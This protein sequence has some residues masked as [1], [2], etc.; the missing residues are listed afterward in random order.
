[1]LSAPAG[2]ATAPIR[3][4]SYTMLCHKVECT[5]SPQD[6]GAC[7]PWIQPEVGDRKV[8]WIVGVRASFQTTEAQGQSA[9]QT[10]GAVSMS[11]RS[12]DTHEY[13]SALGC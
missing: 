2:S 5:P 6:R 9:A 11:I 10:T 13:R 3:P 12:R 7:E 8:R 4:F 1:M